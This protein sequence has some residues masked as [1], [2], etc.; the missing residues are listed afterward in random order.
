VTATFAQGPAEVAALGPIFVCCG[1]FS[2]IGLYAFIYPSVMAWRRGYNPIVWF[3]YSIASANPV[4]L[5]VLLGMLPDR[6]T[7]RRRD[8]Y[9]A[10]LD[11]WLLDE[12][13]N[14]PA[15]NAAPAAVPTYT[16]GDGVTQMPFRDR[17]IGDDATHMPFR[18][19]SIGD[20]L[21]RGG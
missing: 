17:S 21:T 14:P 16:V 19:R 12:N 7:M 1:L 2:I 6:T 13:N 10:E 4:Y 9:A 8:E 5:L 3:L 20:D 11:Y 18:D 15:A